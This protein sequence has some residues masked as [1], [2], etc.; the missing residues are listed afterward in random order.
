MLNQIKRTIV[1]FKNKHL[2]SK[3]KLFLFI[4]P[5]ISNSDKT[6]ILSHAHFFLKNY[7]FQTLTAIPA[8]LPPANH[9]FLAT[10]PQT[11]TQLVSAYPA[12]TNQIHNIDHLH[13]QHSAGEWH[14]L[15]TRLSNLD[16]DYVIWSSSQT[17]FKFARSAHPSFSKAYLFGTGPSLA[18]YRNQ[19]YADGYRIVCNAIVKDPATWDYIEPHLI[20]A[21]DTIYH[22]SPAIYAKKFRRDLLKRLTTSP[23]TLFV[24]PYP[25]HAF[26]SREFRSV[27]SQLVP[28]PIKPDLKQVLTL[29]P[30]HYFLPNLGN[31]LNL[32]LLPL[33][34]TL[35]KNIYLL[36]FDGKKPGDKLFWSHSPR[37]EYVSDIPGLKQTYPAFFEQHLPKNQPNRYVQTHLGDELESNLK[38]LEKKGWTFSL[39]H[40]SHTPA[41]NQRWDKTKFPVTVTKKS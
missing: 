19:S 23:K 32:L 6:Q 2:K 33:G 20:V 30:D 9:L 27:A 26:V 4:D 36:G 22:F 29:T 17:F 37:H 31:I 14:A 28:I 12:I 8:S 5:A 41:L 1:H 7:S 24:Y 11:Y 3:W 38:R 40:P 10:S 13:N 39:M 18:Q 25:F 21:G 16:L 15:L 35:S 34:C